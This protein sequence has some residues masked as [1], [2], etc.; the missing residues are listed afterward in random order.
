VQISESSA[1]IE[2]TLIAGN[3]HSGVSV[4]NSSPAFR[5]CTIRGNQ[6][7]GSAGGGIHVSGNSKITVVNS[8]LWEN[9]P[10]QL[11]VDGGTADVS[12]SVAPGFPGEGNLAEDPMFVDVDDSRLS[13]G[14]PCIDAG[15]IDGAS[16][17]D[18][19]GNTRPYGSEVDMGAYEMQF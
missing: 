15:S 16:D 8:I 11:Q 4:S 5:N 17:L 7:P 1:A 2:N 6:A 12:Y 14:S 18:L 3:A 9:S 19:R 10:N 13:Q